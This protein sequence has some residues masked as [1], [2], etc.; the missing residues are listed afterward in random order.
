MKDNTE[1]LR[2]LYTSYWDTDKFF[3]KK[4]L[5]RNLMAFV[6]LFV[7]HWI[8]LFIT[9]RATVAKDFDIVN[10][11]KTGLTEL[12]PAAFFAGIH[13][14]FG[15]ALFGWLTVSGLEE[16][17]ILD[18]MEK[19]IN[20]LKKEQAEIERRKI[21]IEEAKKLAEERKKANQST[22]DNI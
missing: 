22:S 4:K 5:R 18:R 6:I 12:L 14:W 17:K 13:Y 20:E 15:A 9:L 1:K 2:D 8:I 10:L 3:Q 11:V 7:I 19:E 21:I 16:Q